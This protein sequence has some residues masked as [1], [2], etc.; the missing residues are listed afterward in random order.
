[1]ERRLSLRY[2]IET[3]PRDREG[4][5]GDVDRILASDSPC[6]VAEDAMIMGVVER[7]EADG[8]RW[9]YW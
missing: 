6:G 5:C 1:M 9:V 2:V 8:P 4:L 3:A 7:R